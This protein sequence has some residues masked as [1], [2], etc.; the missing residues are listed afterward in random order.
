MDDPWF[1]HIGDCL[2]LLRVGLYSLVELAR[3]C[4]NTHLVGLSLI[5]YFLRVENVSARSSTFLVAFS[6]LTN[7]SWTYASIFLLSWSL[8][9]LLTKR[10]KVA[11]AFFRPEASFCSRK[12]F[13]QLWKRS[14]LHLPD[15]FGPGNNLKRH[16]WSSIVYDHRLF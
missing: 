13:Y 14:S 11:L 7:I 8:N 2:Y 5:L 9:T 12:Y 4:P 1:T 10:W 15:P 6:H 16:L 3:Y